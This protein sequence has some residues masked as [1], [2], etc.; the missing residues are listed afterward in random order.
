[1]TIVQMHTVE[2]Q[3]PGLVDGVTPAPVFSF[4]PR[5]PNF[6]KADADGIVRFTAAQMLALTGGNF[7]TFDPDFGTGGTF[8]DRFLPL[9]EVVSNGVAGAVRID[10]VDDDGL[11]VQQN[12][13][14]GAEADFYDRDT[15]FV[16][17][18]SDIAF[19]GY[20]ATP[21]QPV[22]IRIGVVEWTD[23][24]DYGDLRSLVFC[25]DFP[26]PTWE[27]VL[28]NNPNSGGN[29]PIL[30]EGDRFFIN[31]TPI[32]G[33][34]TL[35]QLAAFGSDDG[36]NIDNGAWAFDTANKRWVTMTELAAS[37]SKWFQPGLAYRDYVEDLNHWT[38]W[39]VTA[40][41][42]VIV[43]ADGGGA[44]VTGAVAS[45]LADAAHPGVVVYTITQAANSRAGSRETGGL[46]GGGIR[47]GAFPF[48]AEVLAQHDVKPSGIDRF[49]IYLGIMNGVGQLTA[50][51]VG[52]FFVLSQASGNWI[53]RTVNGGAPTN[54]D[55]LVDGTINTWRRF[56]VVAT[57]AAALFY[58]DDVLVATILLTLPAG[59]LLPCSTWLLRTN[60]PEGA[61]LT[62][63][64]VDYNYWRADLR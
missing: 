17:Q 28:G 33:A 14:A 32:W 46:S 19:S 63:L 10:I 29:S 25:P 9:I 22:V 58:I 42:Y 4:D 16:P 37:T 61:L 1:M 8:A 30:D 44:L 6:K 31:E 64:G 27:E 50:P 15:N 54:V 36:L 20:T 56:K 43:N 24:E 23:L 34:Y 48:T 35:A 47:L 26:A 38:Q 7:G 57:T 21:T 13:F 5:S 45:A 3:V 60:G 59:Q 40:G 39:Q 53:A 49:E 52:A 41:D 62:N 12:L 2:F 18:G 11:V 55:T 51:T